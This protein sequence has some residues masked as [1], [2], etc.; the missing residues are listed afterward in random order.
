VVF[1]CCVVDFSYALSAMPSSFPD[2][3]L[4]PIFRATTHQHAHITLH[5]HAVYMPDNS[6]YR[7]RPPL[8]TSS[9]F[10]C[11]TWVWAWETPLQP[12]LTW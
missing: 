4:I 1:L 2:F 8:L 11:N 10:G 9:S 5:I 7:T 12:G 6:L 3:F